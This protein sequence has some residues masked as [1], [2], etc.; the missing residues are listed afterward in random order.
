MWVGRNRSSIK[1]KSEEK[2]LYPGEGRTWGGNILGSVNR[3]CKGP[4]VY[5]SKTHLSNENIA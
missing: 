2:E 4:E 3:M 5:Q 1:L